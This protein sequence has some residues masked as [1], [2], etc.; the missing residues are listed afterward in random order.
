MYLKI[1]V[2]TL[3]K[4]SEENIL[5]RVTLETVR[6]C[7]INLAALIPNLSFTQEKRKDRVFMHVFLINQ[8]SKLLT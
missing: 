2:N 8:Q 4:N 5:M 3:Y 6:T 7:V 1:S